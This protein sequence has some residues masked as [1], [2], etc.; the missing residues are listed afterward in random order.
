MRT[1][2][3]Q[4]CSEW[5]VANS[6]PEAPYDRP[7]QTARFYERALV[8]VPPLEQ[9]ALVRQVISGCEPFNVALLQFTDWPFYKPDEMA[10]LCGLRALHGDPGHLIETPG[11]LFE[12]A[13]RDLLIGMLV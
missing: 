6:I 7:T 2:R 3:R 10:V 5:L 9:A 4:E 8:P 12:S 13:E 11:H 1:L